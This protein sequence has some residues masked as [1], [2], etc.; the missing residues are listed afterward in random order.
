MFCA[1][2]SDIEALKKFTLLTIKI[3]KGKYYEYNKKNKSIT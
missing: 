2:R 1:Y 3:L